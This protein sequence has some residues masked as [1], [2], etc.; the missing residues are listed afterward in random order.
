MVA[1]YNG[2]DG[3]VESNLNRGGK[4]SAST[5]DEWINSFELSANRSENDKMLR[6]LKEV[7]LLTEY[8]IYIPWQDN[9][10]KSF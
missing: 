4:T 9:S 1:A 2:H 3:S 5:N 10:L 7:K 8:S 6:H